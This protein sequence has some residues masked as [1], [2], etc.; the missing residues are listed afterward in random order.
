MLSVY[1]TQ[2]SFNTTELSW[3]KRNLYGLTDLSHS[4]QAITHLK[5][6]GNLNLNKWINPSKVSKLITGTIRIRALEEQ[7]KVI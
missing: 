2:Y 5:I 6:L 7:R 4:I 1:W 3:V